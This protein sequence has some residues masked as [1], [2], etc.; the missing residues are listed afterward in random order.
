MLSWRSRLV[1]GTGFGPVA[2]CSAD[3]A[4]CA[5]Q[6]IWECGTARSH[7]CVPATGALRRCDPRRQI[8]AWFSFHSKTHSR[9]S[10]GS[11]HRAL[12]TCGVCVGA[13]PSRGPMAPPALAHRQLCPCT[14]FPL[15]SLTQLCW[16]LLRETRALKRVKGK[17][18]RDER[19]RA[20]T[21]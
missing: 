1:P 17:K 19:W 3:A 21:G 18:Q 20:Y 15:P 10:G 14:P 12:L 6:R 11:H 8:A 2:G 13:D 9:H 4:S 16:Q 7:K 5:V